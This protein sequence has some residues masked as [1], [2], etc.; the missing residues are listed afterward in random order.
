MKTST[1]IACFVVAALVGGALLYTTFQKHTSASSTVTSSGSSSPDRASSP[2][3]DASVDDGARSP[4]VSPLPKDAAAVQST[5]KAD[6][7]NSK[8]YYDFINAALPA[9][10]AGD[11]DAAYYLAD[12]MNYCQQTLQYFFLR[13]GKL[14]SVDE[15]IAEFARRPGK[16]MFEPIQRAAER[17]QQIWS[18]K[19]PP[20][21]TSEEW[22]AKA[23]DLGQPIAQ[24][25]T[26]GAALLA[27]RMGKVGPEGTAR[28]G[29][30]NE[31]LNVS[32]ARA[33][34]RAAIESNDPEAIFQAGE[35]LLLL[36][37]GASQ[38]NIQ[39]EALVWKYAACLRGA[40][41][42]NG[43]QWIYDACMFNNE[44]SGSQNGLVY[45][46]Q[47][48]SA[49]GLIDIESKARVLLGKI[50]E[51]RWTDLGLADAT[52]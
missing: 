35:F 6:L 10:Q 41:C 4:G 34:A 15:A 5:Y 36:K 11:A 45:L 37:P 21:G 38:D 48:A 23:A 39:S 40:D 3:R 28:L 52:G 50:E 24:V 13:G 8:N 51:K 46:Q 42:D 49:A 32:Q 44:C 19:T 26:A 9:A 33:M 47:A 17:C 22:M 14:L 12:A 30:P 7:K 16:S 1:R 25:R 43:A 20:W 27:M 31:Y 18:T 29:K 2:T